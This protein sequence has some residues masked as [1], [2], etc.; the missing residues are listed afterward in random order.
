MFINLRGGAGEFN[1]AQV[2][3]GRTTRPIMDLLG[4][5]H[6]T[7]EDEYRMDTLLDGALKLCHA[8]R[9][10]VAICITQMLHGGK[11]A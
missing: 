6:F 9:Q 7:L 5:V 10:P 4:L 1:I 11:L 3:M 2:Q 8:N